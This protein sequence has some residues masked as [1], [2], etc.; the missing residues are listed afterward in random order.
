MRERERESIMCINRG[1]NPESQTIVLPSPALGAL[2][3]SEENEHN[4]TYYRGRQ[5]YRVKHS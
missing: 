5:R 3:L 4:E 1:M 2:F